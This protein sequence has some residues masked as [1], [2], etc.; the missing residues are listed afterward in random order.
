MWKPSKTILQTT[1]KVSIHI[2]FGNVPDTRCEGKHYFHIFSN[3][4]YF[5]VSSPK[6]SSSDCE[7]NSS[8]PIEN[9]DNTEIVISQLEDEK[10]CK[11]L[12]LAQKRKTLSH[13]QRKH[14]NTEIQRQCVEKQFA[15]ISHLQPLKATIK[16]INAVREDE[17][18]LESKKHQEFDKS[19][20]LALPVSYQRYE[21]EDSLDEIQNQKCFE[22]NK[23]E[24]HYQVMSDKY[25]SQ[26][27][28][29]RVF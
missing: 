6:G 26:E 18:S 4:A 8:S 14:E 16:S 7:S 23:T 11:K 2:L 24:N 10:F 29:Q 20:N 3:Y 25:L 15:R 13:K 5:K 19:R 28:I 9:L 21:D 17:V 1:L 22:P 12:K 27:L